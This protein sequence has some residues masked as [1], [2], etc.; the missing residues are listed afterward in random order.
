M[1]DYQPYDVVDS[2]S[3]YHGD[4]VRQLFASAAALML[5]GAPFY[6]D[7]LRAELPFEIAGAL[8]L[9][10]LAALM[11]P[12][13]KSIFTA[14]AIVSGIGFTVFEM[15]TL[16]SYR[17]S[18]WAQFVLRELI[19]IIFLAGFYFSMKTLRAF[20]LHKIGKHDEAGEFEDTSSRN[21]WKA[22][23]WQDDFIPWFLQNGNGKSR[24]R[25][26]ESEP[27]MKPRQSRKEI[28]EKEHQS[29]ELM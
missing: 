17:D 13:N 15:W 22:N 7:F 20:L 27:R 5:I 26:Q 14:A 25:K 16:Y 8:V 10:A 2:I 12:H 1:A 21:I 6:S 24:E 29:D 28:Y 18:T 19:S 11:N 9:V 4:A 23:T 3:H